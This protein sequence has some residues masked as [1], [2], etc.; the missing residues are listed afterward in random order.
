MFTR[1]LLLTSF[2]LLAEPI[3]ARQGSV[4]FES[5]IDCKFGENC[6]IVLFVD[7]DKTQ[8]WQDYRCGNLTYDN[9]Q[10]TDI[11]IRGIELMH[12]GI[13][14]KA[15]ASGRV[16]L[17]R[18][19]LPDISFRAIGRD[20]I[21]RRGLGNVVVLNHGNGWQTIYAHLKRTSIR[22]AKGQKVST[23]DILGQV[24]MSGLSEFPHLHFAVLRLGK[25]I[26]PFFVN[27]SSKNCGGAH[28]SLWSAKAMR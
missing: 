18:R 10:G 5:P 20:V 13:D 12:R 16:A 6:D 25:V 4:T 28:K 7:H 15:A 3:F 24:G 14:V 17:V 9:H 8:K 1:L 2:C 22:V 26:D 23:G 19:G 27:S 21:V 11:R